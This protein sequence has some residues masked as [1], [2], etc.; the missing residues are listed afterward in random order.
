M[1]QDVRTHMKP[2]DQWTVEAGLDA[3]FGGANAK[4]TTSLTKRQQQME[5]Q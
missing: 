3:A 5:Q 4:L 1:G 2:Y